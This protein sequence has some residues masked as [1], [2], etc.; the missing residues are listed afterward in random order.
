MS[1]PVPGCP[2]LTGSRSQQPSFEERQHK[3]TWHAF[4]WQAFRAGRVGAFCPKFHTQGRNLYEMGPPD[5]DL[6]ETDPACTW[7]GEA[8]IP[9]EMSS[10]P[11]VM[12]AEL[13]ISTYD[14]PASSPVDTSCTS[15]PSESTS[16]SHM[17]LDARRGIAPER[18]SLG[19][20]SHTL[21]DCGPTLA[22]LG[23]SLAM[24]GANS[25][26]SGPTIAA[27]LFRN[28]PNCLVEVG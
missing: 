28:R 27:K 4:S 18:L 24:I 5:T 6:G 7:R 8:E 19:R 26:D 23:P 11:E 1:R 21:A 15:W 17:L 22:K 20:S 14:G 13:A 2:I 16:T 25:A 10:H 3:G 12:R 9:M